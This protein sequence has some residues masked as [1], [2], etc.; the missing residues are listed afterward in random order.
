MRTSDLRKVVTVLFSDVVDSV[1]L[2][3]TLDPESL[4]HMMRRY[5]EEM[6]L[7]IERHGGTV[8]KFIGDAVVAVFGIPQLHEDDA[9]R[10]VRA[11]VDMEKALA[12][13][14][15]EFERL[16]GVTLATRT[17]MNTGEVIAGDPIRGES[18][19]TGDA[20]NVAARLEQ[21]AEPGQILI[22]EATYRLVREAVEAVEVDSLTLKGKAEPVHAWRLQQVLPGAPGWTRRLDSPLVDRAREL[23]SLQEAFQRTAGTTH[24]GIVTAIGSAGVGK[25][26]LNNEF[27]ALVGSRATVVTGRCLPYGEGITFWPIAA[28]I[29]DAAGIGEEDPPDEALHKLSELLRAADDA[30]LIA[31][32]LSPLLGLGQSTPRIQETF[33]AVRKLFQHLAARKPLIVVF[34]DIQ[35]GDPTFLELL[36]YLA[37]WIRGAPVLIVCLARLELL[38]MRPGW[39]AGK[40]N[41]T[42]ITVEPL[43]GPETSSLIQNLVGGAELARLART[44]IAEVAEGNPLF[45]E[46]TL[47]MLVDDG[48]LRPRN[49]GWTVVGDLSTISI[50]PTIHALLAARLERLEPEERAVIERASVVGRS[51]WWEAVSELS[52]EEVRPRLT[53]YLQSL[54]RKELIRPDYSEGGEVGQDDAYRFTHIL[55][56]DAAYREIPKAMRAELHEQFANWIEVKTRE[57]AGEYEE[58]LGYHLEQA[59]QSLLALGP[60][61]QRVEDV[62]RRAAVL[63]ASA[64]QRAFA[65]GDMPAAVNLLSRSISLLTDKAPERLELLPQLAF[66][67]LETGDFARL[68]ATVAETREVATVA[69]DRSLQAYAL[70]LGLWIRLFTSPEGWTEE[71]Q[72]EATNAI[73]AFQEVGDDRGLAKG[74]S[75]LALV[76]LTNAQFSL[77][78]E[79][80]EKSA[81][82]AHRAGDHRDE[83][84]SLSWVPLAVWAGPTGVEQGLRRCQE[85]FE[86]VEGDRKA[87]SSVLMA[88]AVFVAGLGRFDEAREL[89]ARARSLLQEVA[90]TVWMAGPLAQFAGWVEWLAGDP[91]AAEREFR[92]GYET[93]SDIGEMAWLSTVV[94]LLAEAVYAQG[95][96]DEAEALAQVSEKASEAEDTYSQ[97]AW[98]GV[99]AKVLGRRG[100]VAQAERL[101]RDAVNLVEATDFLPLQWHALMSSGEVLYL[102]G[103]AEEAR[104]L[105]ER[106]VQLA[107]KKGNLV[108]A[109][110]A[111]DLLETM[112]ASSKHQTDR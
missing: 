8:E 46:E 21:S 31:E 38:E 97:V 89:I 48:M 25:S 41:A 95:R 51:F 68:Q 29:R 19:V 12:G 44:H 60:M 6:K 96:Y 99:R 35:W 42:L 64:G 94:A 108:G 87:M 91:A 20:V 50:P 77:A 27:L 34:D 63:L 100:R 15:E 62:G 75:L 54:M 78:Q 59:Y 56:R 107:E 39:M 66:A 1:P 11:A 26:R 106:A 65:R 104:P 72:R 57:L 84:E 4:R 110:R 109:R 22:G 82:H 74:W 2:G 24:C 83:L 79:A 16:W 23:E 14:N 9:L 93:L 70:I 58:I 28:V 80:W 61:T 111:R 30:G 92:A 10:A 67:L 103:R 40:S 88:Q 53:L 36:E 52:P 105:V 112:E 13:L 81:A 32:R 43:T 5:F 37:D 102:I 45:V 85:I 47:R 3:E 71:A 101:A 7:V 18:F 17:G 33:W 55:V 69:G 76:H 49:G 86:R 90:L 98:R 73:T